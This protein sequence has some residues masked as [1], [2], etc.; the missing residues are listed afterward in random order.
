MLLFLCIE[1]PNES[2]LVQKDTGYTVILCTMVSLLCIVP[3]SKL[4]VDKLPIQNMYL[5]LQKST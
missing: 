4:F 2:K 3:S 1:Y 5:P